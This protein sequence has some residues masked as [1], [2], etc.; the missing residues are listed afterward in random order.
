MDCDDEEVEEDEGVAGMEEG[1]SW[2]CVKGWE[3]ELAPGVE[4]GESEREGR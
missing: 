1:P 3:D 4:E 2:A